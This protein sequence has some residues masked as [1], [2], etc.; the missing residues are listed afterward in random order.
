MWMWVCPKIATHRRATNWIIM[1]LHAIFLYLSMKLMLKTGGCSE[2]SPL[3]RRVHVM[4]MGQGFSMPTLLPAR[5]RQGLRLLHRGQQNH[6]DH[7]QVA[8][9]WQQKKNGISTNL[10]MW[11]W[12]TVSTAYDCTLY[13][14]WGP[15]VIWEVYRSTAKYR[16]S[17]FIIQRSPISIQLTASDP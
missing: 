15:F 14:I 13:D 6:S 10:S 12:S 3:L 7:A 5:E 17:H 16:V 2:V 9:Q 1:G 8:T 11:T 4:E